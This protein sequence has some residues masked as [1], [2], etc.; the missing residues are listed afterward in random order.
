PTSSAVA[1]PP[2]PTST[3]TST[4]LYSGQRPV[5]PN[6]VAPPSA[7]PPPA[8][9][10]A[11]ADAGPTLPPPKWNAAPCGADSECFSGYCSDGLCCDTA[12]TGQF[13]ACNEPRY[14]GVCTATTTA[15][16]DPAAGDDAND[17]TEAHPLKTLTAALHA[18]RPN[19]VIVL[20]AGTYDAASGE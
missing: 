4:S 3:T 2:V 9:D 16:V 17:G 12:C 7:P 19:W 15:F 6:P 11:P 20:K 8:T 5:T 10:D 14:E 1:P 13:E 18:A